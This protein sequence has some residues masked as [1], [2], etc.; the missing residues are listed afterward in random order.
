MGVFTETDAQELYSSVIGQLQEDCDETLTEGDERRI[1][2]EAIVALLVGVYNKIDDVAKQT[3]L[4]YARGEI[5]DLIGEMYDCERLQAKKAKTVVRYS[6]KSAYTA[7]ITIP[8]NSRVSTEDEHYFLTTEEVVIQTGD[9]YADVEAEAEYGGEGYNG[10][11]KNTVSTIIDLIS[12]V[13]TVTNLDVTDGGTDE[14]TDNEYRQRIKLALTKF[15]TAGPQNAYRYWAMTADKDIADV[16]IYSEQ[17]CLITIS[18]VMNNG[19][20]PTKEVIQKVKEVVSAADVKPLGDFVTVKAP[21]T[22]EYDIKLKYYVTYENESEA[23]KAI[24]SEEYIDD[25]GAKKT[26]A[27]KQYRMWQ[28]CKIARNI[29]PDK[30]RALIMNPAGDGSI[31]GASRVEILSPIFK[32]IKGDKVAHFSG[33]IEIEREVTEE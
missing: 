30:L 17:A 14:E 22:E 27:L 10:Y 19:E 4:R 21:E 18:I 13:D 1:F 9:T 5:L 11:I 32:E 3:M 15:S 20:L 25:L 28:D 29:N 16:Y 6:L 23:V 7:P 8:R 12:Y 2:G 31:A 24:E 26:G 33:N